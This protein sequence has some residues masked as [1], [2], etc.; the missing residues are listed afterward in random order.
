MK[1]KMNSNIKVEGSIVSYYSQFQTSKDLLE[2]NSS[3]CRFSMFLYLLNLR[4]KLV[5]WY[6]GIEMT[7]L[8]LFGFGT[9]SL[10]WIHMGSHVDL[11]ALN[12]FLVSYHLPLTRE[13]KI[14]L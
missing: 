3:Q 7:S 12:N 11:F 5:K 13:V 2:V 10:E 14:R 6:N 1:R 9:N 4:I 8:C